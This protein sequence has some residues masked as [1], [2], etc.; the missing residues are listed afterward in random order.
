M[1]PRLGSTPRTYDLST[2]SQA[3][4]PHPQQGWHVK[5]TVNNDGSQG[6]DVKHKVFWVTGCEIPPPHDDHDG[7]H[8]NDDRGAHDND[9]ESTTTTTEEPTTTTSESTTTT[10]EEPTTT[11]SVYTTSTT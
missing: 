2:R 3:F 1:G 11:T 8:D 4:E 5:L 7:P 9:S 6:S 10:S